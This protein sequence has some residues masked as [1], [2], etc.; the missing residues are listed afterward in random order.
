MKRLLKWLGFASGGTAMLGIGVASILWVASEAIVRQSYD[1]PLE[2]IAVPTDSASIASGHRLARVLG[3]Y[4]GCHGAQLD[5]RVF[6]DEP[7]VARL[8]APNLTQTITRYSDEELARV[9]RHGVTREGRSAWG[10]PAPMFYHLNDEDLGAVIAYLRS[11]PVTEGPD[12]EVKL[13]PIG[14]VGLLVGQFAP[15]AREVDRTVA[16]ARPA[17]L[18]DP[19]ALGRYVAMTACSECHGQDL[20][21]GGEMGTPNLIAAAAYSDDEFSRLMSTGVA[22]GDRELG[23]MTQVALSR[24]AYLTDEEVRA[25]HAYLRQA[26]PERERMDG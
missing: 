24:F 18:V 11:V 10:M 20:R 14:R 1:I 17:D 5:G 4:D 15:Q 13:G 9:I 19:L 7:G 22:R 26:M 3:C 16:R 25:L 12:V 21:G 2:P 8:V 23:L 6:F